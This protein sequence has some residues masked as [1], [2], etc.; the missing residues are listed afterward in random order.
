MTHKQ[1]TEEYT[2]HMYW[3]GH[4]THAV[5]KARL[6]ADAPA[7]AEKFEEILVRV[8]AIRDELRSMY[9][10]PLGMATAFELEKGA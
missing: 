9:A 5:K 7:Q 10:Q 1:I 6:K 3:L 4:F 2:T 8:D